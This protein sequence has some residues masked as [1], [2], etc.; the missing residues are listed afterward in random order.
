MTYDLPGGRALIAELISAQAAD[1][2]EEVIR[3]LLVAGLGDM[4]PPDSRPWWVRRHI[5]GAEAFLQTGTA[6][7]WADSVV[8]L[9]AIEYEPHLRGRRF[10]TGHLQVRQYC[11]GLL[12]NGAEPNEIRGVLSDGLN[13]YAY[14]ISSVAGAKPYS[15]H[16][17]HLDEIERL[18]LSVA[19]DSSVD[20]LAEFLDRYYGRPDV[21]PLSAPLLSEA[22]GLTTAFG[23]AQL[24][25]L[26][27]VLVQAT[28]LSPGSADLVAKLW[29]RLAGYLDAGRQTSA[30]STEDYLYE[31][32]LAILAR[33]LC[34][35]V[36]S[37]RSL[38]GPDSN[39]D[40]ILSGAFFED[41]GLRRF[42]E[43]DYFGWLFAK[44]PEL[45]R[46]VAEAIQADLKAFNFGHAPAE[47]LFGQLLAQLA[48]RSKRI[49]LGQ[50]WTPAWLAERM[51]T[52]LY[53]LLPDGDDP[54]FI[55]MCCGSGTMLVE[56]SRLAQDRLE[57]Q[58]LHPGSS[59]AAR[60]LERAVV[61]FDIDPLAVNLAKVNWVIANRDWLFSN[62]G[63]P[64]V[65]VP[66]YHAD[67]LF[68]LDALTA[69][70]DTDEDFRL[71]LV[72]KEILAIPKAL[73]VPG[74]Q[75]AFDVVLDGAY[76]LAQE[77]AATGGEPD[78]EV[79]SAIVDE[80]YA[81]LPAEVAELEA[82]GA[83]VAEA[84][85]RVAELQRK[86]RNG[87][88][89]FVL[90]NTYRPV[91]V[92]GQ[93]NGLISNPPWLALSKIG[94]NPLRDSL[95]GLAGRYRIVPAGSSR[96]HL[97][98]ATT[99]LAHSVSHY[100]RPGA[101]ISCV[102]PS[103]VRNGS[104][105]QPFLSQVSGLDTNPR[106]EVS[107][108]SIW[109]LDTSVFKNKGLVINGRRAMPAK[110]ADLP[111]L[112][113]TQG[114][115]GAATA[116]MRE[117][118]GVHAW[119]TNPAGSPPGVA[120]GGHYSANQGA[121]LMPRTLLF[122]NT[123]PS[124]NPNQTV[125]AGV[126]RSDDDA[127][128]IRGAKKCADFVARR[129]DVPS[130]FVHNSYLSHHLA[131]FHLA[132]PAAVVLPAEYKDGW[133]PLTRQRLASARSLSRHFA[134]VIAANAA[135]NS[136]DDMWGA[137]DFRA[138]LSH[139]RF[140]EGWVVLYGAGGG[141][142][143][144]ACVPAKNLTGTALDQTL[145]WLTVADKDE[146]LFITGV[147]NSDALRELIGEFLP[148]GQFGDRH[149]H[150]TPIRAVPSFNAADPAHQA[151]VSATNTLRLELLKHCHTDSN[152]G[153]LLTTE[154]A[155]VER[156]TRLREVLKNL[157]SFATYADACAKALVPP[158]AV[159][160]TDS[161]E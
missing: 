55:D 77:L 92:A 52:E 114:G 93:F 103:T 43:Y 23:A 123:A 8:G 61:G 60:Y 139:Q 145:Y 72:D 130:R 14:E 90:R 82:V 74:R 44:H 49:L 118:D 87:V 5:L 127:Y 65:S 35:N 159:S 143:A 50:E 149:L 119:T 31:L 32:Y 46:P 121:D 63:A 38:S 79:V 71:Q 15:E 69:E 76:S 124:G 45:V 59:E 91:L 27:V 161:G 108:S 20:S 160:A 104:H 94:N 101:G 122:M 37:R 154:I 53:N 157:P 17:V 66:V 140:D 42:V 81:G 120:V 3:Q 11:A 2:S 78:P 158:G 134:D 25:A 62:A 132:E 24:E 12:N 40:E 152:A 129:R 106:V 29:S 151:V 51:A 135:W 144:A 107:P 111:A 58:G 80:A 142:V 153:R 34:A 70:G 68:A 109:F 18:N 126:E 39:V 86:D 95:L 10:Q 105:H 85:L 156:R 16:D 137:I 113:L 33:L 64:N 102:L 48:E 47:D 9:T 57:E 147:L 88:W 112:E 28:R 1:S 136:I 138:K 99:F 56:V 19:D 116:Y 26:G 133:T 83:F 110:W 21:R 100:L 73:L 6:T 75:S 97:E 131:P 22:F 7:G 117:L 148:E 146:A 84:A 89:A 4:Y 115:S 155:M 96:L 67:S 54:H 128:L 125:V 41:K 13:W 36:I 30:F 141:Y 98:L 150:T